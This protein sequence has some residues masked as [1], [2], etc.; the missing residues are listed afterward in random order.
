MLQWLCE[1]CCMSRM[2]RSWPTS[3]ACGTLEPLTSLA[4]TMQLWAASAAEPLPPQ[5]TKSGSWTLPAGLPLWC[6]GLWTVCVWFCCTSGVLQ[7]YRY[8]GSYHV[9]VG[10]TIPGVDPRQRWNSAELCSLLILDVQE[11]MWLSLPSACLGPGCRL[12]CFA[13][14]M[15]KPA[16][17]VWQQQ[18]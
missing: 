18:C 13:S 12:P 10:C 5:P 14:W 7:R 16:V 15:L 4:A 11:Q 17:G 1:K 3:P 8:S 2:W 9:T 6:L